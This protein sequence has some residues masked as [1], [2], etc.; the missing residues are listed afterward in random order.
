MQDCSNDLPISY[1]G[2]KQPHR[3]VKSVFSNGLKIFLSFFVIFSQFSFSAHAQ[4]NIHSG[5]EL[6]LI[7]PDSVNAGQPFHIYA[8][9]F[10]GS[11]KILVYPTIIHPEWTEH[12][13]SY[14]RCISQC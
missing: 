11:G 12:G 1:H 6:S 5:V 4:D 9:V 3:T 7:Y 14:R 10:N 8:R 2:G 13:Y